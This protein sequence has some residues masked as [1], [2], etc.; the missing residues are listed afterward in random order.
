M[1]TLDAAL[2][3]WT[4]F[5]AGIGVDLDATLRPGTTNAKLDRAEAEIGFALPD[6]LR[7][8]Y[9]RADGQLDPWSEDA[10]SDP[11]RRRVPVFGRYVL[12]SLN[13]ALRD[14]RAWDEALNDHEAL[15]MAW[16][17]ADLIEGYRETLKRASKAPHLPP[18]RFPFARDW[19]G[20]HL[21]IDVVGTPDGQVVS[22]G[23]DFFEPRVLAPSVTQLMQLITEVARGLDPDELILP[24]HHDKTFSEAAAGVRPPWVKFEPP[25]GEP[26][27]ELEIEGR[28]FTIEWD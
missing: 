25:R 7:A 13:E 22:C 18:K 14:Y 27:W 3:A 12:L 24:I 28:A 10:V 6:D 8:L 16:L 19:S 1:D 11:L 9:R 2:A 21:S 20:N 15:A 26:E 17:G 5:N 4:D 23:R